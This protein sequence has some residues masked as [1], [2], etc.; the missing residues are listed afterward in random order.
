MLLKKL[1][2][3]RSLDPQSTSGG[4]YFWPT[5]Q[6]S[7]ENKDVGILRSDVHL[8]K[9]SDR[10]L[11]PPQHTSFSLFGSPVRCSPA[12]DSSTSR[13]GHTPLHCPHCSDLSGGKLFSCALGFKRLTHLYR[14]ELSE[15]NILGWAVWHLGRLG[16]SR[17]ETENGW[18]FF[19]SLESPHPPFIKQGKAL[20]PA[21]SWGRWK[22]PAGSCWT[23]NS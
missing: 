7:N 10:Y 17:V 6:R 18:G 22:G 12:P 2:K 23:P 15:A 20:P 3:Q 16:S 13:A 14:P 1:H 9:L 8:R 19:L 4:R 21:R 5:F 11:T